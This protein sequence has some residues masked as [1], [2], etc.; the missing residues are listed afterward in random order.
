MVDWNG[1]GR[2]ELVIGAGLKNGWIHYYVKDFFKA[3]P[4]AQLVGVEA[5]S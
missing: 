5:R 2:E 4:S 1:D 3:P